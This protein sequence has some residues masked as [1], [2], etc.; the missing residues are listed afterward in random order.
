[1]TQ[2]FMF[3][4]SRAY[5]C[6][7]EIKRMIQ[8]LDVKKYVIG[9]ETGKN[10]YKHWQGRIAASGD[11]R[12]WVERNNLGWHVETANDVWDY[13]CKEGNYFRS[14]DTMEARNLFYGKLRDDQ[15]ALLR[16]VDKQNDRMVTIWIDRKGGFGKTYTFLRGVLRGEVLPVPATAISSKKLGG[17]LKSAWTGQKI[18][19]IDIPR[20]AVVDSDLWATIEE[21][22]N[23]VYEW[24]YASSWTITAGVKMLVTTNNELSK[25]DLS[26]LSEDRWDIHYIE[27][28]KHSG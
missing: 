27:E 23:I 21:S 6:K 12:E 9:R 2:I 3:T 4:C 16:S 20:A 7:R 8:D 5:T 13:E 1:M 25:K 15:I 19:W 10:G 28:L 14:W 26:Q 22:K 24:R 11:L 18:I 17:W